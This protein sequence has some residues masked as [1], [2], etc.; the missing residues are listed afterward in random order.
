MI[1]AE[2]LV[3]IFFFAFCLCCPWAMAQENY[4]IRKVVFFGNETLS[5]TQLE[6][7]MMLKGV[8][9]LKKKLTRKEPALFNRNLVEMDL[10]RIRK[11]YQREGFLDAGVSLLPPSVNDKRKTL[12]LQIKID[13]GEPFTNDTIIVLFYKP[14]T[15]LNSDSL[16]SEIIKS[17]G[18]KRGYRFRDEGLEDCEEIIRNI[19]RNKGYAY[20]KVDHEIKLNMRQ[21]SVG[22]TFKVA[23]GPECH[24]GETSVIGNNY[25]A[26]KHILKEL[27]YKQGETY[28]KALLVKTRKDLNNLDVFQMVSVL[29]Q[30]NDSLPDRA[31]P[32]TI[33]VSEVP[34]TKTRIGLG[35]G[36]ED[37]FR[38]FLNFQARGI[39]H[40]IRRLD[41]N[42]K[43][44]ALEPYHAS[45]QWIQPR[46]FGNRSDISVNP[47][48]KRN[49][50]PG[51]D[52]RMYGVNV[53]LSYRFNGFANSSFMFYKQNVKLNV[54]DVSS[55]LSN[56][57]SDKYLYSKSGF[58]ISGNYNN[59]S[60]RFSPRNG[61]NLA[62]AYKLNGYLFGGDFNYSRVVVDFRTYLDLGKPALALRAK[63]G[64]INSSDA[65]GYIPV[66][67]RFYTGGSSSVRGWNRAELGPKRDDGTPSGG[68]SILEGNIEL[69][70]PILKNFS[71]VA[72]V[73]AGN[74][75]KGPF[76]YSF[77]ELA[78]ATGGGIRFDTPIGPIRFDV[79]IPVWN[80]KKSPQFF[81]SVGQAF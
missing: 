71:L 43:H 62:A 10:E 52:I 68:K 17:I 66:E 42:L 26:E 77:N 30:K 61:I 4:E 31:I 2:N 36:T 6:N 63:A 8:G 14:D 11:T 64:G 76:N 3:L 56:R 78:Y 49:T 48:F 39:F 51:Y 15:K 53:P 70:Y 38:A 19:F 67:D 73:D 74:V 50:E 54:G 58:T 47:F 13:E 35:Y 55:E 27:R 5:G 22:V 81:I 72:F 57:E 79:G 44:S 16:S 69:R 60:P 59:S 7:V 21:R 23:L 33:F 65:E 40:G 20:C 18:L 25:I 32:I 37:K 46:L 34:R 45:L 24:F 80:N 29:P 28:N 9:L 12:V 75:W 41:L 1:K